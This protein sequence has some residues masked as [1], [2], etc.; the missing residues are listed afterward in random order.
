MEKSIFID[1]Q[2]DDLPIKHGDCPVCKPL[3][4]QRLPKKSKAQH[5]QVQHAPIPPL[6]PWPSG[7][8]ILSTNDATTGL[9]SKVTSISSRDCLNRCGKIAAEDSFETQSSQDELWM[10]KGIHGV[11]HHLCWNVFIRPMEL[12]I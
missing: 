8:N 2:P 4:T 12:C 1:Y 7:I 10:K 9:N 11:L 6:V 3:N 5:V